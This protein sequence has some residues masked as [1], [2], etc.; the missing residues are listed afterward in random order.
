MGWALQ[1]VYDLDTARWRVQVLTTNPVHPNAEAA[2]AHVVG[3]ARAGQPL[4]TKAIRLV[5]ASNQRT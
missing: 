4:A 5:M 1:Y 3:Q 2:G